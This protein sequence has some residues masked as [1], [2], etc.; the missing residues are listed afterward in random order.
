MRESFWI[1]FY[2]SVKRI[3]IGAE[4]GFVSIVLGFD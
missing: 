1:E 2:E 4:G 3:I